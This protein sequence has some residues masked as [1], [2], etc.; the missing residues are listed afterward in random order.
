VTAAPLAA[1]GQGVNPLWYATRATGV[2]ALLVLTATVLLGI[3]GT[4][5]VT[6][7]GLPRV[8][9]AGL[10]RNLSLLA[11]AL[12]TV[13]VV[14]TVA[15]PYAGISVVSAVV[16]FTSH[17]R[18][19]WLGLGAVAL[20]LLLAVTV[21]SLFRDRLP[22]R[23][24]RAVHWLAYG[25]WPVALWHGLGT[26]TDSR[27]PLLLAIDALCVA[28]VAAAVAWR[29][30][31]APAGL[32]RTVAIAAAVLMPVATAVFVFVGPLQPGWA[33]RAGTPAVLIGAAPRS[34]EPGPARSRPHGAA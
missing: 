34:S 1:A 29:L 9:I 17:Y 32:V 7:P 19:F 4:G 25:C 18:G 23:A 2:V 31:L 3:A 26:G 10:H 24:W 8:V 15:D 33:R 5:R 13:H 28:G 14:T 12:I 20:D 16:P 11:V 27:L 21:T 30:T 22:R 6:A